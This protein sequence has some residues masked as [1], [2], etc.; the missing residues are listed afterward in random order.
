MMNKYEVKL[1]LLTDKEGLVSI[2]VV[3]VKEIIEEH[4]ED[5][6]EN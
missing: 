4:E 1:I 3:S 5:D 2:Q 6:S